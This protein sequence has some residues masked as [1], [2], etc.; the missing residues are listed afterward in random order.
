[1]KDKRVSIDRLKIFY[2]RNHRLPTY[3]EMM[4]VLQYKSKGSAHYLTKNLIEEGIIA[5]D[6]SGQ[7]IPKKLLDIPLLGTIKAGHPMPAEVVQESTFNFH[8]LF[9]DLS[10]DSFALTVSGDSMINAGIFDGDTVII[11]KTLEAQSGD[12]VAAC[13]DN[14]WTVKY[15]HKE[16]GKDAVLLPANEKYTVITPQFS[17]EI[18]G[19][20]KHVIRSYRPY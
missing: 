2:K 18:G 1:M 6:E 15:L 10:T 9:D 7:L 4:D 17:L 13:V 20:V 19:V 14:E 3:G 5:K 16:P 11:D 8:Y 12:V